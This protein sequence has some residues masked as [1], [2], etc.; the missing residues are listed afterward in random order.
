MESVARSVWLIAATKDI[1]LPYGH[2]SG[3]NNGVVDAISRG[4]E[5]S[6]SCLSK[7]K[8]FI[9]WSVDGMCFY[10]NIFA[11]ALLDKAYKRLDSAQ[12]SNCSS[13]YGQV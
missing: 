11:V 7:F 3:T 4:F 1:Y 5:H 8:H 13:L 10:P 6:Q 2:I 12:T 9:G